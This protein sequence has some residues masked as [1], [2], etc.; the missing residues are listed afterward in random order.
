MQELDSLKNIKVSEEVHERLG[1][2][3]R[4][5]QTMNDVIKELL[6]TVEKFEKEK[7]HLK[8]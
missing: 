1:I 6:D 4:Y 3:G 8:K 2:R 7:G 5:F